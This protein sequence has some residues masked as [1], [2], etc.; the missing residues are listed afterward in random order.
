M[1]IYID[2][3]YGRLKEFGKETE[4]WCKIL[5]PVLKRFVRS[6]DEPDS[7]EIKEFWRMI[8]QPGCQA[9]G[10]DYT[11]VSLSAILSSATASN[12]QP[13]FR[14]GSTLSISGTKTDAQFVSLEIILSMSQWRSGNPG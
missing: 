3:G 11:S 6:F 1:R 7:E 13:N 10:H 5:V 14:V 4:E 9:C 2:G 12:N 8:K